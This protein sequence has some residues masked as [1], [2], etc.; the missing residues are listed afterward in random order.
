MARNKSADAVSKVGPRLVTKSTR[1]KSPEPLVISH[2]Q[3]AVRAYELF[4]LEGGGDDV[5]QWLRAERELVELA[6]PRVRKAGGAR[7]KARAALD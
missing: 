2:E 3:I 6:T 7:T 5:G 1:A 4:L